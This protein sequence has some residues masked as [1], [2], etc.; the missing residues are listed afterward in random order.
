MGHS[1][2]NSAACE[3]LKSQSSFLKISVS[4]AQ[5]SSDVSDTELLETGK[6]I[7]LLN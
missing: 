7:T 6:I 2:L 1:D 4:T 5:L 3:S